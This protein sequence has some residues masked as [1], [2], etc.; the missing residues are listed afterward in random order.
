MPTTINTAYTAP[1]NPSP[2]TTP[3]LTRKQCWTGLQRKIRD[4]PAFVGAISSCKVIGEDEAE[5]TVTRVVTFKAEPDKEI[6]EVCRSFEDAKVGLL[7]PSCLSLL[8]CLFILKTM[9]RNMYL[10]CRVLISSCSLP[11]GRF[12]PDGRKCHF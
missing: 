12:S 2:S 3:V 4:A 8:P 5:G 11:T 6:K 10:R 9:A 7:F 1:I